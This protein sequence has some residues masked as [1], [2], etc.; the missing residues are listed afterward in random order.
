MSPSQQEAI[1][2]AVG[3]HHDKTARN[4]DRVIETYLFDAALYLHTALPLTNDADIAALLRTSLRRLD[5]AIIEIRGVAQASLVDRT[6]LRESPD[7]SGGSIVPRDGHP[8]DRAGHE[9]G[10]QSS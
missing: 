10:S 7:G 9:P 5:K 4:L 3:Y 2:R 8:D 1:Q 6:S